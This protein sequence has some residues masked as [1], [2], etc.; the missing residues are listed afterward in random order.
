MGGGLYS[1]NV[2]LLS[3]NF[4]KSATAV[5]EVPEPNATML[6]LAGLVCFVRMRSIVSKKVWQ[7]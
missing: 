7:R 3:A 4:G 6:I 1:R 2:L 5:V